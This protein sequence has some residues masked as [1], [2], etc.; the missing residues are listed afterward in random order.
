MEQK[1]SLS[2]T[3]RSTGFPWVIHP[4]SLTLS[5]LYYP[6]FSRGSPVGRQWQTRYIENKEFGAVALSVMPLASRQAAK[7]SGLFAGFAKTNA[8]IKLNLARKGDK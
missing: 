4:T 7:V 6:G 3:D 8:N 1:G 5:G 2:A